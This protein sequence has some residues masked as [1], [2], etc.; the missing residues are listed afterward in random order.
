MPTTKKPFRVT[1]DRIE[2]YIDKTAQMMSE[3]PADVA[4]LMLPIWYRL[5]SEL[6][7]RREA[8][9]AIA[10]ARERFTRLTDRTPARSC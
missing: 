2:Q 7:K 6:A 8:E 9:A 4:E 10:A 1:A 5:H 3:A